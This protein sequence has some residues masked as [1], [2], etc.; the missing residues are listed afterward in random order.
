M[1]RNATAGNLFGSAQG[2]RR[3]CFVSPEAPRGPERRKY[4]LNAAGDPEVCDDVQEWGKWFE[5]ADDLRRIARDKIGEDVTVST[6]FLGLDHAW[7]QGPPLLFE[8][9]IFGGPHSG[10]QERY[11]TKTEALAGHATAVELARAP[12]HAKPETDRP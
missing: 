6:V 4:I 5:S 11:S 2:R 12:S 9:M 7:N 1:G 8:T 3:A 10:Y